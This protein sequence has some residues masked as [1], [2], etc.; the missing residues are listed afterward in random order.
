M[1]NSVDTGLEVVIIRS[2]LVYGSGVKANFR[3]L[4]RLVSRSVP[5][6]LSSAHNKHSFVALDNLGGDN[7]STMGGICAVTI[8]DGF[9]GHRAGGKMREPDLMARYGRKIWGYGRA[10]P[11]YQKLDTPTPL[12]YNYLKLHAISDGERNRPHKGAYL[13]YAARPQSI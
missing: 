12:I 9:G 8:F 4:I 11:K 7:G 1:I 2:P 6:A 3:L 10:Y 5:L 13:L